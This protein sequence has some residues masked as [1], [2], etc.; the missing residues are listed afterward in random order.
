MK[1]DVREEFAKRHLRFYSALIYDVLEEMGFPNQ[2]LHYSISPIDPEMK[3]AGPAFTIKGSSQAD[4]GRK[5][6]GMEIL[7]QINKGEV[8]VMDTGHD[9]QCGHW[10]EITS[11]AAMGQGCVGAVIDGGSRDTY[12]VKKLGFPLFVRFRLP[13]EAYGRFAAISYQKPIYMPGATTKVVKLMP[14]DYIFGDV[15]GI[16][17]VPKELSLQV[18]ERAEALFELEEKVRS[19]LRAGGRPLQIFRKYGVF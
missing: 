16:I 17:V 7:E 6:E 2:A 10:G 13:V 9:E 3:I 11:T 18:L 4:P 8:V 1:A 19:E 5:E 14:G 15:D 12:Y